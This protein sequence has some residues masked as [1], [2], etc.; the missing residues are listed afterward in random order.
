MWR[1]RSAGSRRRVISSRSSSSLSSPTTLLGSRL[2]ASASPLLA[3]GSA[4]A[5]QPQ[6]DEMTGAKAARRHRGLG[7]AAADAGE[8]LQG[9][10]PLLCPALEFGLGFARLREPRRVRLTA[11]R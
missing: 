9:H 3:G 4:L 5:E 8:V 7:G 11:R 6:R 1:R 10:E 2:S